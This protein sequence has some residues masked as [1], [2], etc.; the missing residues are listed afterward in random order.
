MIRE[1][2]KHLEA[3]DRAISSLIMKPGPGTMIPALDNPF[4]DLASS[5]ISPQISAR[6]ASEISSLLR[7]YF[8]CGDSL[9][10]PKG[11]PAI[12]GQF[13]SERKTWAIFL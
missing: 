6:G 1:A 2:V 7:E 10:R 11:R 9:S 13:Q 5:I 4:H 3:S 12:P 8:P